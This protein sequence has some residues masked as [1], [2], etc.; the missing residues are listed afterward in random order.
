MPAALIFNRGAQNP[1]TRRAAPIKVF[2]FFFAKKNYFSVARQ[3]SD[4]RQ[5]I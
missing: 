3:V 2:W 1:R 5:R 4:K